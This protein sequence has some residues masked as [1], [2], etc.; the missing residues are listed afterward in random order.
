M[1]W[2]GSGVRGRS[3][4]ISVLVPEQEATGAGFTVRVEP[5]LV[6]RGC[7]L[8][9]EVALPDPEDAAEP[10]RSRPRSRP[11]SLPRSRSMDPW[12]LR[13]PPRSPACLRTW[14]IRSTSSVF[15][16][17]SI[18][19]TKQAKCERLFLEGN[20]NSG[21]KCVYWCSL[22]DVMLAALFSIQWI[23][24]YVDFQTIQVDLNVWEYKSK[25]NVIFLTH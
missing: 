3:R 15:S 20:F 7:R 25:V 24:E 11:R 8:W 16:V 12:V 4:S 10:P 5:V 1:W 21:P 6:G 23:G 22:G 13:R 17:L 14:Y 18:M 2:A 19:L 9:R